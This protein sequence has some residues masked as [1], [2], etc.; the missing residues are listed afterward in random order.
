MS[1]VW[2][3]GHSTRSAD[4]F[5]ALLQAYELQAVADVRRHPG[6]R[7]LPQ[8]DQDV[9]ARELAQIGIAYQWFSTLGGRRRGRTDSINTGWRND[10]FRAYA[11]H[12]ESEEFLSGLDQL[13]HLSERARTT[14]MCAE[15]VWWR[16]HRRLIAD[17]LCM[18]GI[19]VIHI[20]DVGHSAPHSLGPPARIVEGRLTYPSADPE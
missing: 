4:E 10:S 17:V 14:L 13:L 11:D 2:T 19:E 20:F 18:R 9:L 5:V 7:R 8:F 3:V 12:L 6:S 15:A 16:C 1:T